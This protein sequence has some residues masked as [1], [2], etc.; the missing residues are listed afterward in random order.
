TPEQPQRFRDYLIIPDQAV[1]SHRPSTILR[2]LSRG[3]ENVR[4]EFEAEFRPMFVTFTT[5]RSA[6]PTPFFFTQHDLHN[7]ETAGRRL[8][9][10]CAARPEER[11]LNAL[12]FAPHLAFWLA[13]YAGTAGGVMTVSSGGGKVMGTEGNI[14]HLRKFKPD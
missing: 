10:I 5:G 12:P 13:H 6:E 11:L 4:K 14:R 7:L 9:E 8:V 3:R 1:L 2:A